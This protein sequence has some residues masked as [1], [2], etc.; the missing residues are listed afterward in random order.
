MCKSGERIPK[1]TKC[2]G[3]GKKGPRAEEKVTVIDEL[4]QR[5]SLKVLLRVSG[6]SKSTYSYY[7]SRKHLNAANRRKEEDDRILSFILP[8]FEHHKSRYGYRRIVLAL[9]DELSGVNHKRIQRI[10]RENSLFGKQP[11]N[12]YHSYKGDNGEYKENLLL[13]KEVDEAKH[14][15]TYKRDFNTSKPNQ[16][17]ATDVSEFKCG[18]GKLYLSPIMDLYDG[19]IISYDISTGPDFSQTRRM[20][21]E[22]FDRY[23]DLK[24]LI[25]HSDQGW[26][27]QMKEYRKALKDKGIKQSMSRKGNCID[28]CIM[29]T[30]FSRMKNEMYYGHEPEYKTFEQFYKAVE[31]YIHYYN[32]ERIQAKTKWMPP[33]KYREASILNR[34]IV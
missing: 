20:I 13:H 19:S 8:V 16:K 31:E 22:A 7:H 26:Q 29:E 12:K 24:G 32:N 6:L 10:M 23:S 18:E 9:K 15:M 11:K 14:R 25:F 30:F 1:K 34:A 28:N 3:S 5:Y 2:L 17:W 33:A 21:D 27:Y 4:R